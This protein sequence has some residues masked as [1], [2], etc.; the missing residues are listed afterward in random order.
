MIIRTIRRDHE[1]GLLF[2]Y[3]GSRRI[4]GSTSVRV[5]VI[6]LNREGYTW[7]QGSR[8]EFARP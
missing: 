1:T 7:V 2:I 8:G 3:D 5:L 4:I 6:I